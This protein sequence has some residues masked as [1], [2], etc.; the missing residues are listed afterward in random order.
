MKIFDKFLSVRLFIIIIGTMI[1][2]FGFYIYWSIK[3]TSSNL[4]LT[5]YGYLYSSAEGAGELIHRSIRY[6]MFLNEKKEVKET[7]DAL[8][9]LERTNLLPRDL[10]MIHG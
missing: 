7:L 3:T 8:V 6:G 2:I 4:V 9:I 5:S 10:R 1:L